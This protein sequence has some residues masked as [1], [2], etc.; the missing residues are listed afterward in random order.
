MFSDDINR[1]LESP[2]NFAS[3]NRHEWVWAY[4]IWK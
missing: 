2:D 4:S 1:L 3:G